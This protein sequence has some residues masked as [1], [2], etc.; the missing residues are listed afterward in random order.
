[1]PIRNRAEERSGEIRTRNGD[2]DRHDDCGQRLCT[3][4]M[5][6]SHTVATC[7]RKRCALDLIPGQC[8]K[9][10]A[11][12]RPLASSRAAAGHRKQSKHAQR[13]PALESAVTRIVIAQHP[14]TCLRTTTST[15]SQA[16]H[17]DRS[18]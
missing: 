4:M 16:L 9:G 11:G 2:G 17:A 12:R 10:G 6:L 18:R 1:M 5:L 15:P 13:S 14:R 7:E 8:P 3:R